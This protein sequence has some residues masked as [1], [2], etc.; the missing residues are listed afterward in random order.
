MLLIPS[1]TPS[2]VLIRGCSPYHPSHQ[3]VRMADG[4]QCYKGN[5]FLNSRRGG[6][7]VSSDWGVLMGSLSIRRMTDEC[8]RSNGGITGLRANRTKVPPSNTERT[9]SARRLNPGL[10]NEMSATNNQHFDTVHAV[11]CSVVIH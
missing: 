6:E 5:H 10:R 3:T 7:I 2:V 1:S 9:R 4:L 8:R 11:H